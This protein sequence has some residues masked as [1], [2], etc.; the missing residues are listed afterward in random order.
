MDDSAHVGAEGDAV[1]SQRPTL[2][3]ARGIQSLISQKCLLLDLS[4]RTWRVPRP[5]VQSTYIQGIKSGSVE[6]NRT[7]ILGSLSFHPIYLREVQIHA[8]VL[9]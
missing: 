1:V 7:Y 3:I 5:L 8:L 2:L 4:L 9:H 6:S